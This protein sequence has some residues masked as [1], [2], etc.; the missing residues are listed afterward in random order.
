M[1]VTEAIKHLGQFD[2]NDE[3]CVL[4]YTKDLFDFLN[5]NELILTREA[6]SEVVNDFDQRDFGDVWENI[7]HLVFDYAGITGV[8]K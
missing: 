1:K 7:Y 3:L 6:W 4:F 2:P 5:E 8:V